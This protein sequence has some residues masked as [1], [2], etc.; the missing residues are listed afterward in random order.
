MPRVAACSAGNPATPITTTRTQST[1]PTQHTKFQQTR[2]NASQA[3]QHKLGEGWAMHPRKTPASTAQGG[4]DQTTRVPQSEHAFT[5]LLHTKLR[6]CG[7]QFGRRSAVASHNKLTGHIRKQN[8]HSAGL[9]MTNANRHVRMAPALHAP[10]QPRVGAVRVND[11]V[12]LVNGTATGAPTVTVAIQ[13]VRR[14]RVVVSERQ[15]L[16][17]RHVQV[18]GSCESPRGS[19][20]AYAPRRKQRRKGANAAHEAPGTGWRGQRLFQRYR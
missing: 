4:D 19:P 11:I 9:Q 16:H 13:L 8:Q 6:C 18:A 12:V 7:N 5:E 15:A 14:E 17:E 10:C 3:K 1:Q 2:L 20:L